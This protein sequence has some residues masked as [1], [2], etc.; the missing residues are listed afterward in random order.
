MMEKLSL[1]HLFPKKLFSLSLCLL[2]CLGGC[3]S[4]KKL[5]NFRD[6]A[7]CADLIYITKSTRICANMQAE[8]PREASDRLPRDVRL[9]FS[10]PEALR[11]LTVT[12]RDG[13]ISFEY[14]GLLI[15]PEHTDLLRPVAL[16]LGEDH[17]DTED[18]NYAIRLTQNTG[19]PEE[20]VTS[21]EQ[22]QITDFKKI[23][24]TE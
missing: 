23:E 1:L 5:P 20:I 19:L 12:R 6:S 18:P 13:E 9:C 8:A 21:E 15:T 24:K 22:L 14:Q 3:T 17:T 16:L 2:I 11:G 7:F 4:R 10:A